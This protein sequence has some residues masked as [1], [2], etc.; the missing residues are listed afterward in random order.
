MRLV[1]RR[2]RGSGITSI[3]TERDDGELYRGI[4]VGVQL[5]EQVPRILPEHGCHQLQVVP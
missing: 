4:Y 5:L 3:E 1:C 2:E